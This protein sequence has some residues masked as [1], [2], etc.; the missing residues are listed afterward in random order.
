[1]LYV[2]AKLILNTRPQ[3]W[4]PE[5]IISQSVDFP[6]RTLMSFMSWLFCHGLRYSVTIHLLLVD[7]LYIRLLF[8]C[9]P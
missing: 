4:E 6:A 7:T 3:N 2:S 8:T 1:M 9:L 5:H